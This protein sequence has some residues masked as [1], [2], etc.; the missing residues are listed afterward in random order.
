[1]YALLHFIYHVTYTA[2]WVKIVFC[3]W[4]NTSGLEAKAEE[5]HLFFKEKKGAWS[6]NMWFSP[7]ILQL[8]WK[9]IGDTKHTLY[10]H[11]H[12]PSQL[13]CIISNYVLCMDHFKHNGILLCTLFSKRKDTLLITWHNRRLGNAF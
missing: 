4:L 10:V 6:Q 3:V 8:I 7:I 13:G 12:V 2:F 11:V 9:R 1:M 5:N